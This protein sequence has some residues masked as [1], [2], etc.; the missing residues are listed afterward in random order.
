MCKSDD[1]GLCKAIAS[2]I[3]RG[4]KNLQPVDIHEA[5]SNLINS[6]PSKLKA[7]LIHVD[8]DTSAD[9]IHQQMVK[10]NAEQRMHVLLD[11]SESNCSIEKMSQELKVP[12]ISTRM[13]VELDNKEQTERLSSVILFKQ[14]RHLVA[15]AARDLI[16]KMN[17]KN[18]Q[19]NVLY[20]N[21]YS[22]YSIIV[23][24]ELI[25]SF[26]MKHRAS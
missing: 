10:L 12:L 9:E 2:A 4:L 1:N 11:A 7:I 23:E 24:Q 15:E 21:D 13:P 17:G 22:E 3:D 16:N 18:K 5:G 19:I 25:D 6:Q 8:R 20:T 14:A 26:Q